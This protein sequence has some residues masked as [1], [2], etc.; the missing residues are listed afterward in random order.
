MEKAGARGMQ[1]SQKAP[2]RDE[3]QRSA[4]DGAP[5][6]RTAQ[7]THT[8]V[9]N[10]HEAPVLLGQ[11]AGGSWTR[12]KDC[13]DRIRAKTAP[14][15]PRLST[16]PAG[17]RLRTAPTRPGLRTAPTGPGPGLRTA[18]TRPEPKNAR[19]ETLVVIAGKG[20]APTH[21]HKHVRGPTTLT[22]SA[23][24]QAVRPNSQNIDPN[25]LKTLNISATF[26]KTGK[27]L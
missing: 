23:L 26:G 27:I 25:V 16:A 15:G 13:S 2:T 11:R 18:P 14:T 24:L 6:G 22:A 1:A 10:E 8:R 3:R 12:A 21:T 9:I 19:T 7:T 4:W 5:M 20:Q 17:P